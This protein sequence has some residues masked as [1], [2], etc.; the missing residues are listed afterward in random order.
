LFVED[1]S[2]NNKRLTHA[3]SIVLNIFRDDGMMEDISFYL[4]N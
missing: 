3:P 1:A 2:I 4:L